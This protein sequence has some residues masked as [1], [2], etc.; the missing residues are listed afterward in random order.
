[1][2][3]YDE[4]SKKI[5]NIKMCDGYTSIVLD[6]DE[7]QDDKFINLFLHDDKHYCVIKS[8]SR[9]VYSQTQSEESLLSKMS[10][11]V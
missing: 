4:D 9:L 10:K 1:M 11:W 3:G 7:A 8:L 2:Y 6:E 5:Y